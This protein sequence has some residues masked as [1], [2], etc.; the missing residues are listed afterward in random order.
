MTA[1]TSAIA[2]IVSSERSLGWLVA[3]R[4][5]AMPVSATARSTSAKRWLAVEV[6]PVAVH[7]LA[8]QRDLEYT[9]SHEALD[10]GDDVLEGSGSLAA[11]HVRHDAV[12]CRSCRSRR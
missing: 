11:A 6:A 10:L 1:G 9:L 12:A 3:N 7:V 5:R 8:E 2:A 4:M